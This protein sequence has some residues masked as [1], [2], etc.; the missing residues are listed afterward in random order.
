MHDAAG[1]LDGAETVERLLL[2]GANPNVSQDPDGN[3]PLHIAVRYDNEQSV[4]HLLDRG[5]NV[6]V[7]DKEGRTPLHLAASNCEPGITARLLRAGADPNVR[8]NAGRTPL[9]VAKDRRDRLEPS[10]RND[11]AVRLLEKA[12]TP[13]LENKP[14]RGRPMRQKTSTEE[15]YKQ[16]ADDIIKPRSSAAPRRGRNTGSPAKTGCRR[17]SRTGARYQGGNA[18]QLMVKRTGRAYN[19]QPLGYLQADQRG[20]GAGTERRT[21]HHGPGLQ[22]AAAG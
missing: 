11:E 15:Y 8:D 13:Q 14:A 6:R 4:N 16:F 21:G 1:R 17:T 2:A 20:R 9:D 22:A 19:D 12:T 7:A 3:T 10:L 18:L 5:A